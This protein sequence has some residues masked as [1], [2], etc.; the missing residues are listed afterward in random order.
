MDKPIIMLKC[1]TCGG[2]YEENCNDGLKYYHACA[3][4]IDITGKI[5]PVADKRDEN[6]GKRLNGKGVDQV[7]K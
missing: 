7:T 2:E 5:V 1:K 4:T 6:V 3:D